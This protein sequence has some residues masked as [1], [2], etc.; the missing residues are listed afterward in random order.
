MDT[1]LS[2][3]DLSSTLWNEDTPTYTFHMILKLLSAYAYD[4]SF[5]RAAS[6]SARK[7]WLIVVSSDI[8]SRLTCLNR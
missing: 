2:K 1:L 7:F 8:Q 4:Y 3:L 6:V 5:I